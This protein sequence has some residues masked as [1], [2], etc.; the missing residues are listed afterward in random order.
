MENNVIRCSS[1]GATLKKKTKFCE[2]CGARLSWDDDSFEDDDGDTSTIMTVDYVL[3]VMGTMVVSG[4]L[5]KNIKVGMKVTNTRNNKS[6]NIH[7][8][9]IGRQI[10]QEAKTG[11]PVGLQFLGVS[12]GDVKRRG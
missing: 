10:A 9:D 6:F 4:I 5:S 7:A 12:K 1:C 3:A 8:I 2:Y 11:Q